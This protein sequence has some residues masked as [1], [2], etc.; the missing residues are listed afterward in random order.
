MPLI[1]DT[2]NCH[3]NMYPEGVPKSDMT[4]RRVGLT[5]D[6]HIDIAEVERLFKASSSIAGWA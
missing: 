2:S 6:L 3:I 1:C 4:D 5:I